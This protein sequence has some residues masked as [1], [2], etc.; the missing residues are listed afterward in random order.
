MNLKL[1]ITTMGFEECK[2]PEV[3]VFKPLY[4][5]LWLW[6][7]SLN[8][9]DKTF[10]IDEGF[11]TQD[12]ESVAVVLKRC[13]RFIKRIELLELFRML[14]SCKNEFPV[15]SMCLKTKKRKCGKRKLN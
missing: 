8:K 3:R 7:Q 11:G 4:V 9:N 12:P 10:F 5:W 6:Q 15:P 14:L 1:L 13:N 2:T